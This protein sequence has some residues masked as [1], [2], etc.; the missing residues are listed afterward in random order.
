METVAT[1]SESPRISNVELQAVEPFAQLPEDVQRVLV[2]SAIVEDLVPGEARS[3]FGAVLVIAGEISVCAVNVEVPAKLEGA[4]SFISSRGSL[5]EGVPLRIIGS[6][7]GATISRWSNEMFASAVDAHSHALQVCRTGSDAL[8]ARVGLTLG[9]LAEV[10]LATR[11]AMLA[12]LEVRALEP[13]TTITEEDGPMPGLVFVVGGTV[14]ILEGDP[15]AV[16]AD[17]RPGELLFPEALWAGAA[18]PLWSRAGASGALILVGD[19]RLALDLAES[20]PIVGEL[21]SR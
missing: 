7:T 5:A 18:A 21:L 10:D 2:R 16:V 20:V 8:Q 17:V 12:R 14:E 3:S 1:V 15:A 6:A 9:A 4:R 13:E 11:E 19:R